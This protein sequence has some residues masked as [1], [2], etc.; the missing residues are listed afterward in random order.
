MDRGLYP[1]KYYDYDSDKL[2]LQRERDIVDDL[3]TYG[4][5]SSILRSC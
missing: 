4:P 2:A 1:L 5:G 3:P